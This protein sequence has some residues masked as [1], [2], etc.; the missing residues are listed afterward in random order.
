M[1]AFKTD[2]DKKV[3]RQMYRLFSPALGSLPSHSL[4]R[5]KVIVAY[6]QKSNRR[7]KGPRVFKTLIEGVI[8]PPLLA[9]LTAGCISVHER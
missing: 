2:I 8:C 9:D 1:V 6:S 4:I 5:Y 3:L 7:Y